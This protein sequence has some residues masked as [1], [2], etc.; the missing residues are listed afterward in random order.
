MICPFWGL[1]DDWWHVSLNAHTKGTI[2]SLSFSPY[3]A[4][5]N[6]SLYIFPLS[7]TNLTIRGSFRKMSKEDLLIGLVEGTRNHCQIIRCQPRSKTKPLSHVTQFLSE[8]CVCTYVRPRTYVCTSIDT[9]TRTRTR[10]RTHTCIY[11]YVCVRARVC[12]CVRVCLCLCVYSHL[13]IQ[14]LKHYATGD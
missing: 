7:G 12:A 4:L 14:H 1:L 8:T 2:L 10:T 11:M 5:P 3:L 6:L 9:H 13:T